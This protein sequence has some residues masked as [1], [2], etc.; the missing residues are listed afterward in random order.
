[1]V[2][3]RDHLLNFVGDLVDIDAAVVCFLLI[4][5][6]PALLRYTVESKMATTFM[7]LLVSTIECSNTSKPIMV[8]HETN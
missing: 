7:H 3:N 1:M 8:V 5:T 6:V 4:V 2:E